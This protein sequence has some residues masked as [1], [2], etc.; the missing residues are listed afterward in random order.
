MD[1]IWRDFIQDL[2]N[3][4]RKFVEYSCVKMHNISM[5]IVF[6]VT[7]NS[8]ELWFFSVVHNEDD[9]DADPEYNV[10]AD[11]EPCKLKMFV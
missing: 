10:A 1:Y 9:D 4:E 8:N 7:L 2:P 6:G 3:P 5:F 11:F